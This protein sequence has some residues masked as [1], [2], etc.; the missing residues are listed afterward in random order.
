MSL[1]KEKILFYDFEIPYLLK[2]EGIPTGGAC[3]RVNNFAKG[4]SE[5]GYKVG[6]LTWRGAN[7]YI[8]N[9]PNFKLIETYKL[10]DGIPKARWI[11]LRLPILYNRIRKFKPTYLIIKSAGGMI[12]LM[13]L[14][15]L[16]TRTKLVFMVTNDIDVDKRSNIKLNFLNRFLYKIGLMY[17]SSIFCQNNYQLESFRK[18]YPNK[19]IF[20]VTNPF[21]PLNENSDMNLSK[22][23][24]YVSWLGIFQAQKNLKSLLNIA[25]DNPEILFH[26]A[27]K[28]SNSIDQ[29]TLKSI[30][31]LKKLKNVKF[32]G[33]LKRNEILKFLSQSIAL[34]NTSDYE[35]FSNTFLESFYSGT[36]IISLN[37]NPDNILTDYNIGY[38]IKKDEFKY[39]IDK[40]LK[41]DNSFNKKIH[42]YVLNKHSYKSLS[43]KLINNLNNE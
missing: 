21:I 19:N 13:S 40:I 31:E 24:S 14:I 36:P 43:K 15:C 26:I 5:L 35:G 22:K 27:G 25:K 33:F 41:E 9:L 39:V 4:L 42:N 2:D 23:R 6:F 10:T 7:D 29:D 8:D 3:V 20:K 12:G 30:N 17:S 1:E 32:V 34:L 18:K 11:Y 16:F 37:A 38:V 28:S